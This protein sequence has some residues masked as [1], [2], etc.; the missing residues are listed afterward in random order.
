MDAVIENIK[1]TWYY[2]SS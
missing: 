2:I 1:I